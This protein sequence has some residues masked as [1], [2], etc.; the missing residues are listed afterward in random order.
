M[1]QLLKSGSQCTFRASASLSW[2]WVTGLA[3]LSPSIFIRFLRDV[4]WSFEMEVS[5]ATKGQ[6]MRHNKARDHVPNVFGLIGV[7]ALKGNPHTLT[8]SLVTTTM[9]DK[10]TTM[11][12]TKAT[13]TAT[14]KET[15]NT[16]RQASI[17]GR[18]ATVTTIDGRIYLDT[19]QFGRCLCVGGNLRSQKTARPTVAL[20]K[21][22][23]PGPQYAI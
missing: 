6:K 19:Q 10:S 4:V 5:H 16:L 22:P 9:N 1:F 20:D 14:K 17:K 8:M 11:K 13:P 18:A 12:M 7:H 3:Q 23:D 2:A 21:S 15:P